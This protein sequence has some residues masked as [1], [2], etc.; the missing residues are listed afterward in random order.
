MEPFHDRMP[1]ILDPE[2]YDRWLGTDA[3][4]PTDLLRPYPAEKMRSWKVSHRVGN[5][6]NNDPELLQPLEKVEE[7]DQP[8]TASQPSLFG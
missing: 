1:V 4:L 8:R 3:P 2:N 6:R 7:L 5:V